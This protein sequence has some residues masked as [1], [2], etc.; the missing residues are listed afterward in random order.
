MMGL[1]CARSIDLSKYF[2]VHEGLLYVQ[3]TLTSPKT[4]MY[5]RDFL[6]ARSIDLSK[7]GI[8]EVE[9][10]TL[11]HRGHRSKWSFIL[12]MLG[13][14]DGYLVQLGGIGDT[15]LIGVKESLNVNHIECPLWRGQCS[16]HI[17]SPSCTCKSLER[18]T[19][20]KGRQISLNVSD[21]N[22]IILLRQFYC[23]Y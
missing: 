18:S 10:Q 15:F 17:K 2:H 5:M 6:C 19:F 23:N 1:L 20:L 3:G 8:Q 14:G 4:C 22:H 11:N 16:L 9:R 21:C 13:T 7:E 12:G